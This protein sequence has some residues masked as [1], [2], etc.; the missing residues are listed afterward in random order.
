MKEVLA[1]LPIVRAARAL[2]RGRD[3]RAWALALLLAG[4]ALLA[5]VTPWWRGLQ[6]AL[7]EAHHLRPSSLA[8]WVA[9]QPA[10][11]MY[12]FAHRAWLGPIPPGFGPR[13]EREHFWVNHYPARRARFDGAR[14]RELVRP[15]P[16]FLYLESSYRGL[17]F[18]SAY[19]MRASDGALR[20][21]LREP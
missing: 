1:S 3:R 7:M 14:G 21:R 17:R 6:H 11:K 10:P 9:L 13:F 16:R 12:S 2:R 4:Y 5:L 18:V 19:E 15:G 8:Q 20:L